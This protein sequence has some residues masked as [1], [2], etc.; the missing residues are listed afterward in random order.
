MNLL[1]ISMDFAMIVW[2]MTARTREPNKVRAMSV[3][4][5]RSCCTRLFA[6]HLIHL[7]FHTKTAAVQPDAPPKIASQD[8]AINHKVPILVS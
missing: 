5:S 7:F 3:P 4:Q 1:V 8:A 2:T 6:G